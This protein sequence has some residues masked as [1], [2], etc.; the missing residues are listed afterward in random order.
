LDDGLGKT[1]REKEIFEIAR[2]TKEKE[3][4]KQLRRVSK[5][6]DDNQ[7]THLKKPV[8]Q[9]SKSNVFK[10]VKSNNLMLDILFKSSKI[11]KEMENEV[12]SPLEPPK[13][14]LNLVINSRSKFNEKGNK[15]LLS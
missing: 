15:T 12:E 2:K 13:E 9:R 1:E 14:M 10:A 11:I 8:K 6:L 5:I 3:R 7:P 4:I